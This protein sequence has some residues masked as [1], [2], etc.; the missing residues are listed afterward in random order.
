M[1][2]FVSHCLRDLAWDVTRVE[3]ALERPLV[4]HDA[5][6]ERHRV[7]APRSE[8]VAQVQ[9]EQLVVPRRVPGSAQVLL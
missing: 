5:I 4:D 7:V 2:Q 8:W 6:R 1:R 3:V 9:A